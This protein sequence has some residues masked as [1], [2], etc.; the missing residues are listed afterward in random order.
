[1]T[2]QPAPDRTSTPPLLPEHVL[3]MFEQTPACMVVLS[4]PEHVVQWANAAYRRL[5]G[6]RPLEGRTIAEALP[7][8]RDQGFIE[9]LDR[10]YRTGEAFKAETAPVGLVRP[11]GAFETRYFDFVYQPIRRPDGAVGGILAEGLEVTE[12]VLA[13]RALQASEAQFADIFSQ[14]SVGIAQV[15]LDGRFRLVNGRYRQILGRSSEEILSLTMQEVT[16]P[17][18]LPENM[19]LYQRLVETG[20]PF[21]IEKR[22]VRPDGSAVWVQNHVSLVRDEA[23]AP[24]YVT[25]VVVDI[26]GQREAERALQRSEAMSK[27]MLAT[28]LDSIVTISADSRVVEWNP[29]AERTFGYARDEALG[30]DMAELIIP[31]EAREAH[32]RGMAAFLATGHGPLVA[33]RVEVEALTRAGG[34]LPVELAIN[35]IQLEGEI[36]FTAFIRDIS[37]RLSTEAALRESEERL[38]ATYEHAFVGIAEVDHEGRVLRANEQFSAIAGFP[39]HELL[40]M[41]I[42]DLT[43]PEDARA[44]RETFAR[45]MAGQ[46]PSYRLEKRYVQK[47]GAVIWVELAASVVH[48]ANGRPSYGVRVVRDISDRKRWEDRQA[49]LI[50][51]LNH[52][53]K[54]TLATVQSIAAQTRRSVADPDDAYAAFVERLVALSGAHDA[55]TRQEWRGADLK[56]IVAGAIEPFDGGSP[57]RFIVSGPPVWLTPQAAVAL[58]LAFHEL[59]TNAAKYGALTDPEGRVRV[60]WTVGEGPDGPELGLTWTEEGGPPVRPPQRKGFGSRLLEHGLSA[61]LRGSVDVDYRPGGVV[62]TIRAALDPPAGGS[63]APWPE[64]P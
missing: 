25:A 15:E 26:S 37:V 41:T 32:R 50:N 51:E 60:A 7:E 56:S 48:D 4:G 43:H 47:S 58:A 38:R 34:R 8:V 22:Y 18:D 52:R 17:D 29:A 5:V 2:Q 21:E 14:V 49:L 31:P 44:E 24:R 61:E 20:E 40:S 6:E 10:C 28:A 9:I 57:D 54:N 63:G 12:R 36:L 64:L 35:P 42:W 62:C 53:V 39:R 13:E 59:A 30:R 55:L 11:D 19:R 16:H 23:G 1:M 46:L 45:H 27:A 33:R 3:Q